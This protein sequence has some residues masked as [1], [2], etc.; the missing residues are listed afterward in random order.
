M[1]GSILRKSPPKSA[2]WIQA[3]K[4]AGDAGNEKGQENLVR[5]KAPGRETRPTRTCSFS[6]F[7]ATSPLTNNFLALAQ[8]AKGDRGGGRGG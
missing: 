5:Q 1:G 4:G 3:C 8:A 2:P 7:F 6:R